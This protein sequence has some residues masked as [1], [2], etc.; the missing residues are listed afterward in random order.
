MKKSNSLYFAIMIA[1][2]LFVSCGKQKPDNVALEFY[3]AIINNDLTK[4]KEYC[5]PS[6]IEEIERLE[7]VDV[8]KNNVNKEA[9]K[10]MEIVMKNPNYNDGDTAIVNYKINNFKSYLTL[11]MKE[12]KWKI[13]YSYELRYLTTIEFEATDF[14]EQLYAKKSVFWQK[15]EGIFF[16]IKNLA[17]VS[18]KSGIPYSKEKNMIYVKNAKKEPYDVKVREYYK[19]FG[20]DVNYNSELKLGQWDSSSSVS[21]YLEDLSNEEKEKFQP[22]EILSKSNIAEG[23]YSDDS[24]NVKSIIDFKGCFNSWNINIPISVKFDN[25]SVIKVVNN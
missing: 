4:A 10:L 25:C 20:K 9:I 15:Y 14:F 21:F 22:A 16:I 7:K 8:Y 24:Y 6:A 23:N 19:I 5:L 2:F 13:A 3:N 12:G 18:A 1:S 11:I 17:M